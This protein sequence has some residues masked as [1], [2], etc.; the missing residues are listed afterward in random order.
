MFGIYNKQEILSLTV[1]FFNRI[2]QLPR[3]TKIK[4]RLIAKVPYEVLL[5]SSDFKQLEAR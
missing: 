5:E 1:P 3:N 2:M 4:I